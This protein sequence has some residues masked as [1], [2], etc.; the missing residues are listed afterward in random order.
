[1]N[2]VLLETT[3]NNWCYPVEYWLFYKVW[4]SAT[5]FCWYVFGDNFATYFCHRINTWLIFMLCI[6]FTS[7]ADGKPDMRL[8]QYCVVRWRGLT[9][10]DIGYRKKEPMRFYILLLYIFKLTWIIQFCYFN[11]RSFVE[12]C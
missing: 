11:Y 6:L 4:Y 8:L 1:M 3:L 2:L 9:S 7:I 10:R 12:M 5:T